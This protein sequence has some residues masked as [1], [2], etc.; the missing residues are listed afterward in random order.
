MEFFGES[1]MEQPLKQFVF[2]HLIDPSGKILAQAEYEQGPVVPAPSLLAKAGEI[3]RNSVQF[4]DSQLRGATRIAIGIREPPLTFLRP[5]RDSGNN[6]LMLLIP[7]E[8]R[9]R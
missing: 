9:R 1:L 4:S 7:R 6:G 8:L 3:W 5:D 2:V